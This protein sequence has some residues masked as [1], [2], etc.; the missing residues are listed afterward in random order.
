MCIRDRDGVD[1]P[2]PAGWTAHESENG[3]A[4]Y[5]NTETRASSWS[6]PADGF[7]WRLCR[8]QR[9]E[10][11]RM[12]ELEHI[13]RVTQL[14]ERRSK[15]RC[16]SAPPMRHTDMHP[17]HWDWNNDA[18]AEEDYLFSSGGESSDEE[19]KRCVNPNRRRAT[20]PPVMEGP[21]DVRTLQK[22]VKKTVRSFVPRPRFAKVH[23]DCPVD[24][25]RVERF[26]VWRCFTSRENLLLEV[27]D[28]SCRIELWKHSAG[29]LRYS[30]DPDHAPSEDNCIDCNGKI[31]TGSKARM[32]VS[33]KESDLMTRGKPEHWTGLS[34]PSMFD[35]GPWLLLLLNEEYPR[36]YLYHDQVNYAIELIG[37][38]DGFVMHNM[39]A[40][41]MLNQISQVS[42][43]LHDKT[44]FGKLATRVDMSSCELPPSRTSLRL[45]LPLRYKAPKGR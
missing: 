26:G 31:A 36:L 9:E 10:N 41:W 43:E 28:G 7:Y 14:K 13:R 33:R 1:A 24:D 11:K 27:V 6:H 29:W 34:E 3:K 17:V 4:Y 32:N 35:W 8:E 40:Q 23:F 39:P 38:E 37:S 15:P 22:P 21:R 30:L 18:P 19:H 20:A 42:A 44:A 2:L 12:R 16:A 25:R 45:A 5:H